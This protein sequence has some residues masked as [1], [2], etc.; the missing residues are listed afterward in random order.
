MFCFFVFLSVRLPTT[1]SASLNI[2]SFERPLGLPEMPFLKAIVATVTEL[3]WLIN[4]C[5][6]LGP[7]TGY[8]NPLMDFYFVAWPS[9]HWSLPDVSTPSLVYRFH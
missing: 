6:R 3:I 5:N 4:F 7:V 2:L 1:R 8:R 9:R